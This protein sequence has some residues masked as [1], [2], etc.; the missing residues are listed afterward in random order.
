M[1]ERIDKLKEAVETVHKCK[2]RHIDSKRV[3]E[4][5]HGMIA[6]DGL[7]ETFD[8]QGH[9]EAKRC[10]AWS[11]TENGEL[12]YTSVLELPPVDSPQSAVKLA[13]AS[14]ARK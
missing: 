3:I 14:N 7:V 9:P 12:K 1:S 5:F 8:L 11:F 13:I 4:L 2:A 10:Y 6:W